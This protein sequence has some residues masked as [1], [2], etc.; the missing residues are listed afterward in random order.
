VHRFKRPACSK[1]CNTTA[2]AAANTVPARN[3]LTLEQLH[4]AVGLVAVPVAAGQQLLVVL[5]L[6]GGRARGGGRHMLGCATAECG[7]SCDATAP[8]GC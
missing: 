5:C 7:Q 2:G 6:A 8:A 3:W 1:H 4:G